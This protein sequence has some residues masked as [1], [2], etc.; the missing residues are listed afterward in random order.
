MDRNNRNLNLTDI[1][2]GWDVMDVNGDK[3]G[4]VKEVNPDYLT[5]SKGFFF[6]SERYIPMQD[7]RST[8]DDKVFLSVSKDE[9]KQ[10][11]WDQPPVTT[12][13]TTTTTGRTTTRTDTERLA[14]RP[15]DQADERD[16]NLREE[17]LVPREERVKAGEVNLQTDVVTNEQTVDVPVRSE[18]V[19]VERNPVE[20]RR[21]NQPIGQEQDISVPVYKDKVELE[22]EPVV[23]EQVNVETRPVEE[24]RRVKGQ[25]KKEVL[26]VDTQGDV[27]VVKRGKGTPPTAEE[28]RQARDTEVPPTE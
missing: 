24:T 6:P 23:Y 5:V 16:I 10:E 14:D 19:I 8:R 22:K 13:R 27:N 12:G 1:Q 11:G 3:V 25:V 21:A 17:R 18:E 7:V 2:Q 9:L 15:V 28:L 20:G 26:D 4:D